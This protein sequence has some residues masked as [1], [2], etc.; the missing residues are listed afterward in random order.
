MSVLI[1]P[2][3]VNCRE[4]LSDGI[5]KEV[6]I[7]GIFG[8]IDFQQGM[9]IS[10]R[11]IYLLIQMPQNSCVIPYIIASLHDAARFRIALNRRIKVVGDEMCILGDV[12]KL[13]KLDAFVQLMPF[14]E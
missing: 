4:E 8:I 5:G 6:P 14:F 9:D 7:F 10:V 13:H 12:R 3:T 2:Q 1:V 11:S